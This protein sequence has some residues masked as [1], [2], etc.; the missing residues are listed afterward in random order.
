MSVTDE[1][2]ISPSKI[3]AKAK[4]AEAAEDKDDDKDKKHSGAAGRKSNGM[5]DFIAKCKSKAKG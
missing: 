5:L 3:L 2:R 4:K 1:H